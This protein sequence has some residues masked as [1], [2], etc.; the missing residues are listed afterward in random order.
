MKYLEATSLHFVYYHL[1]QE[2]TLTKYIFYKY[3]WINISIN[4]SKKKQKVSN[5]TTFP[6]IHSSPKHRPVSLHSVFQ[7]SPNKMASRYKKDRM[8]NER[9]QT[10]MMPQSTPIA[11]T[12]YH[13]PA[14]G[15]RA[16]I[17]WRVI[18]SVAPLLHSS[19]S[20]HPCSIWQQSLDP[21]M[22][23][24]FYSVLHWREYLEDTHLQRWGLGWKVLL[25]FRHQPRLPMASKELCLGDRH[26][27]CC[28]HSWQRTPSTQRS[29]GK[30]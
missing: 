14:L 3:F 24:L 4:R 6:S 11:S 23:M 15:Q 22:I 19:D 25:F 29:L 9:T 28:L 27:S 7:E 16:M 17:W 30:V 18:Y 20:K 21:L 2:Q 26:S 1:W 13:Q 10:W 8:K 5:L 12:R